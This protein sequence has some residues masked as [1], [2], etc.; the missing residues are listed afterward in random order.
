MHTGM[1]EWAR[2]HMRIGTR[3]D[4]GHKKEKKKKEKKEKRISLST[5]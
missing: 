3:F 2:P 1:G 4:V 5:V